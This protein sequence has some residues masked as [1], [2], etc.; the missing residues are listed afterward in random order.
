M[1][2]LVTETRNFVMFFFKEIMIV[3]LLILNIENNVFVSKE[4]EEI[5]IIFLLFPQH[6]QLVGIHEL[7][8]LIGIWVFTHIVGF[9]KMLITKPVENTC[10]YCTI[11]NFIYGKIQSKHFVV[12]FLIFQFLADCPIMPM[13]LFF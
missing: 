6:F 12:L 9:S 7:V 5:T 10:F 13:S 8:L 2:G 4:M 3:L 1:N 11:L